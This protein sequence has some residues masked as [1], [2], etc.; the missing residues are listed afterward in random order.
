M[1]VCLDPP[2]ETYKVGHFLHLRWKESTTINT[3]QTTKAH[4]AQKQELQLTSLQHSIT[5]V[6]L[7]DVLHFETIGISNI[8]LCRG[9]RKSKGVQKFV[10]KSHLPGVRVQIDQALS[11]GKG[12]WKEAL[13]VPHQHTQ[14]LATFTCALMRGAAGHTWRCR[15]HS[16]H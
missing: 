10:I 3:H 13:A 8:V 12:E 14:T 9:Q 1:K 16:S 2:L 6:T 11:A 4:V 7:K 15:S 5:G